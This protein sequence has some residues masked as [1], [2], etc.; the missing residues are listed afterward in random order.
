MHC[1]RR[2][3]GREQTIKKQNNEGKEKEKIK[4]LC[5]CRS[6]KMKRLG[7]I[8]RNVESSK[9]GERT[10]ERKKVGKGTSTGGG[11]GVLKCT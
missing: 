11:R 3:K 9:K 8:T 1:S 5:N 10:K 4:K 7:S 2:E 6:F